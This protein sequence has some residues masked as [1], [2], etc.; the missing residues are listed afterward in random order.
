MKLE[1]FGAAVVFEARK[2]GF[3]SFSIL[4]RMSLEFVG[5][6]DAENQKTDDTH[7]N[8]VVYIDRV[9]YLI[10]DSLREVVFKISK[11]KY[12]K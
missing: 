12:V 11:I 4:L 2:M 5:F 8:I 6:K 10:C 1:L 3:V 7:K 9:S